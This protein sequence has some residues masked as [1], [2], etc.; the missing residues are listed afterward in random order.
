MADAQSRPVRVAILGSTGSIGT[1]TLDVI[2]RLPGRFEV[3]A[4]AAGRLSPLLL[5]QAA[6]VRPALVAVADGSG[7]TTIPRSMSEAG[8]KRRLTA[9]D[10][11]PSARTPSEATKTQT[12]MTRAISVSMT[13]RAFRGL[14][15]A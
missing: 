15:P 7:N 3:V 4:L 1:Q 11:G 10:A 5:E 14:I 8:A 13:F 6:S 2:S 12:A 9:I